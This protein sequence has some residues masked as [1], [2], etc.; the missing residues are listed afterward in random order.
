M[1][2]SAVTISKLVLPQRPQN[3]VPDA[4]REP[5]LVQETISGDGIA[6]PD[7]LPRLP[8]CEGESPLDG[9]DL[10]CAWRIC[11]SE[12]GRISMMR[13]S[14][15]SPECATRKT[16]LPGGIDFKITRPDRPILP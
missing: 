6:T 1:E 5:H 9:A 8:P 15:S 2:P 10:N 12:S 3:L 11:S 4:K 13:S 16:C 14:S 7:T